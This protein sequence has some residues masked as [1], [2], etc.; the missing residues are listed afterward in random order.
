MRLILLLPLLLLPAACQ[1]E[2]P[3]RSASVPAGT[4][5]TVGEAALLP[6]DL[7][8]A[9][10]FAPGRSRAETLLALTDEEALAQ[11]A[12]A[13]GLADDPSVRA[14]IR[15][16]LAARLREKHQ[17]SLTI[18]D[19][20]VAAAALAEKSPPAAPPKLRLAFL[21]QR[22]DNAGSESAAVAKLEEA[23]TKWLALPADASRIAFGPLAVEYSDDADTR[24]Q[25]G[26]AGWISA[27]ARHLLLPPEA[28]AAIA[29]RHEAGLLPDIIRTRDAAWLLLVENI[30]QPAAAPPDAAAVKARLSAA[31]S[32]AE[33]ASLLARAR[34]AAPVKILIPAPEVPGAPG[35]PLAPP[36]SPAPPGLPGR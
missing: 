7:E 2:S 15:R 30:Q 24:Y 27:G 9:L 20:E 23:R 13:E 17:T 29:P 35:A 12:R 8:H 6:S 4:V 32:A 10:S 22:F 33:E 26:D 21:R 14:A 28:T 25:G 18:T 3:A 36:P 34:A 5:A 1:K 31:R 19:A 11:L 16:M